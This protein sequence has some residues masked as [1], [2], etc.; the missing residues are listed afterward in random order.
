MG[1]EFP[2]R[3]ALISSALERRLREVMPQFPDRTRAYLLQV[4]TL[5]DDE[6][7]REIGA[8]FRSGIAPS[9]AEILIDL[10]EDPAARALMVGQL[11]SSE[12]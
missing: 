7:A 4:L 3:W 5:P 2:D 1:S 12:R 8:L 11:R 10:E 6:R 9:L